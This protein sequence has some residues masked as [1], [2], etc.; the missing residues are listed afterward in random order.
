MLLVLLSLKGPN[1][2]S[3]EIIEQFND[4]RVIRRQFPQDTKID[5]PRPDRL[6]QALPRPDSPV[7]LFRETA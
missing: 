7:S 4:V 1:Q 2:D 6:R 5:Q 3:F